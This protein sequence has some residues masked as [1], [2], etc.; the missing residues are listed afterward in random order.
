MR[1]TNGRIEAELGFRIVHSNDIRIAA[2][3]WHIR[4]CGYRTDS[5]MEGSELSG[6]YS[7][8][9]S[10]ITRPQHRTAI[11]GKPRCDAEPRRHDTP[12]VELS[13]PRAQRRGLEAFGIE[14][15]QILTDGATVI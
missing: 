11:S 2:G 4:A 10:S 9:E 3:R 8:A 1:C 13:E 6:Q 7:L 14:R 12:R 15:V 5:G